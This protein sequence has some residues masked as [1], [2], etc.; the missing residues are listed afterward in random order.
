MSSTS[1]AAPGLP[2]A[3]HA[4]PAAEVVAA[5]A[6]DPVT[7]L[8]SEEVARRRA[9]HGP[10][11]LPEAPRE[12]AWRRLVRQ[13]KDLL[14][15]ILLGAAAVSFVVSGELKTP[16]VVLVVVV[17]NAVIGFVQENRAE[18]SLDALRRMLVVEVRGRSPPTPWRAPTCRSPTAPRWST[19]RRPSPGV[20]VPSW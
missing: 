20:G 11:E 4:A 8:S 16:L 9:V 15:L 12:P 5:L 2:T 1:L 13:L 10:N 19:C 7:G 14:T 3:P 18:A 6:V 17:V